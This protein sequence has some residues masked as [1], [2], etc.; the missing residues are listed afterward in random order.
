MPWPPGWRGL[1]SQTSRG[2]NSRPSFG[3]RSSLPRGGPC[4]TPDPS[5]RA[6]AAEGIKNLSSMTADV[7]RRKHLEGL[8]LEFA[9]DVCWSVRRQAQVTS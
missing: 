5:V 8:L 1:S 6:A 7:E 4:S 2:A 9:S 3:M